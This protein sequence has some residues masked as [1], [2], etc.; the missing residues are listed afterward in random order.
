MLEN[1][2]YL[3]NP[4]LK[5]IELNNEDLQRRFNTIIIIII[6]NFFIIKFNF[7][8]FIIL[9]FYYFIIKYHYIKIL[10]TYAYEI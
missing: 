10:K 6:I 5:W 9:F 4:T 7:L 8:I 2:N 3:K 1:K